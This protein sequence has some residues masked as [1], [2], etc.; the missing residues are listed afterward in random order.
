MDANRA[1][2]GPAQQAKERRVHWLGTVSRGRNTHDEG[3]RPAT[4]ASRLANTLA[5][6]APGHE[7]LGQ[8]DAARL[9]G[10]GRTYDQA[11]LAIGDG[12]VDRVEMGVE[13]QV[14]ALRPAG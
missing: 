5:S 2:L 1:N 13:V 3:S 9:P 10:L 6:P 8:V 7:G 4:V 11:I 14:P 12:S